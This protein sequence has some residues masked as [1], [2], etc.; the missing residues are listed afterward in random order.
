MM[1]NTKPRPDLLLKWHSSFEEPKRE[2]L[3]S[4]NLLLIDTSEDGSQ[5]QKN[6][7]FAFEQLNSTTLPNHLLLGYANGQ[8][9]TFE[10]RDGNLQFCPKKE[11]SDQLSIGLARLLL[12][13]LRAVRFERVDHLSHAICTLM[14]YLKKKHSEAPLH[15]AGGK[16]GIS[17]RVLQKLRRFTD[18][19]IQE[20][21]S[22]E[23]L[24][25]VA[26]LST[27]HFIRM[28]K[29][30]AGITPHRFIQRI[31]IEKAKELLIGTKLPIVQICFEVGLVNPS[32]FS[33]IFKEVVGLPPRKFRRKWSQPD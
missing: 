19:M 7:L 13:E 11:L 16:D 3:S 6:L 25:K 18:A 14:G 17:P 22:I 9:G 30:T 20:Q 31:R 1:N 5:I 12:S 27:Y 23:M 8:C 26:G 29:R 28:F 10:W 24:A 2:A 21:I 33:R 15:S 4:E 32:H